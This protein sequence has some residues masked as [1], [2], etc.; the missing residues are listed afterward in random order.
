MIEI[1]SDGIWLYQKKLFDGHFM[2]PT[3]DKGKVKIDKKQLIQILKTIN[4]KKIR[5]NA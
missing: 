1:A 3:Y 2:L 5:N 4:G